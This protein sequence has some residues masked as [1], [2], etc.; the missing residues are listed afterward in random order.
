MLIESSGVYNLNQVVANV[1]AKVNAGLSLFSFYVLS[2]ANSNTDGVS[3][4]VANPYNYRGE[5]GP[6]AIDVRHRATVGGSVS[7]RWGLRFS[8]FVLVQ[9]GPPFDITAGRDLYGT[10]LFNGRPG[11]VTDANRPGV[12]RT[13]YGL[14]D[15]N[16]TPDETLLP[17]NF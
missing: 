15:S 11:I 8:P 2:R 7:T 16:P 1:N 13:S 14:L 6:A 12:I 9:S 10:T 5:Y 17:R 4:S 3:T